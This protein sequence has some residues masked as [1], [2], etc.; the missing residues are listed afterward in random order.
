MKRLIFLV[1]LVLMVL[2][3]GCSSKETPESKPAPEPTT[4][5]SDE[6]PVETVVETAPESTGELFLTILTPVDKTTVNAETA[7]VTGKTLP[8]AIVSV[9]GKLQKVD[10]EGSF[11]ASVPLDIGVNVIQIVAS[12]ISGEEIGKVISVGRTQ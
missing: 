11:T 12:D 10:A 1:P 4:E 5:P 3:S 9:N 7:A 2:L 6:T 8:V